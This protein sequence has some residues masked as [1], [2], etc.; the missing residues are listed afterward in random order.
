MKIKRDAANIDRQTIQSFGDEWSKFDQSLLSDEEAK[1][2]FG[3]YF[4]IFPWDKLPPRAEGFDMGCGTGR[5][6]RIVAPKVGKLHCIDPSDAIKVAERSLDAHSNIV[7]HNDFVDSTDLLPHS[8]DFGYSIGVLHHIPDTASAMRSCVD[9]LKPKAPFLVYIYYSFDNRPTW[10]RVIWKISDLFRRIIQCL[11]PSI[12]NALTDLIAGVVYWPLARLSGF[13]T[14]KGVSVYSI[15]LSF[16]KDHSFY[17]M[18]TDARDR[19]GTPLEQRFS[20]LQIEQMMRDAGL[21]DVQFSES[22]PYWCAVG[23]KV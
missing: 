13:L 22:V 1:K 11:P 21:T 8:Q 10:F 2:I 20:K 19:F 16:Y 9:L 4:T 15:P 7:F 18:R 6:A 12:K 17:T 3:Q 14:K 5:W 23:F